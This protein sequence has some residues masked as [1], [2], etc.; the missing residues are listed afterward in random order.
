M[1]L[2][3]SPLEG[4]SWLRRAVEK[5]DMDAAETLGSAYLWGEYGLDRDPMTGWQLL[6]KSAAASNP[7]AH[8]RPSRPTAPTLDAE[9]QEG[10]PAGGLLAILTDAFLL[11]P[12]DAV[13]LQR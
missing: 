5:R 10:P 2:G 12:T 3:P 1:S 7:A 8:P 11:R 13:L 4:M 9:S 6:E